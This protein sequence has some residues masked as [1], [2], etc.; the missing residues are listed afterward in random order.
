MPT[1][2]Y[3]EHFIYDETSPSCL[4]H[5]IKKKQMNAGDVAGTL[6]INKKE[7]PTWSVYCCNKKL[8]AHRV[9]WE[10]YNGSIPE[11]LVIDHIDGDPSN[12]KIENLRLATIS[13]NSFNQSIRKD[14]SNNLPKGISY[15]KGNKLIAR[16]Q[17][18]GK[19]YKLTVDKSD[20]EF[21]ELW[22]E[23]IREL[24]HKDFANNGGVHNG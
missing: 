2:D 11:G 19:R 22:V 20:L 13:Q 24:L 8:R 14:K 18:Y 7:K 12:N 15:R 21:A 23:E 5:K 17:A 3:N 1:V 9:I 4:R 10:M 6:V 16:V